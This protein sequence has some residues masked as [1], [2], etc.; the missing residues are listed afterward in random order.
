[1]V[2]GLGSALQRNHPAIALYVLDHHHGVG[3]A[4]NGCAGHDL[5]ALP[6]HHCNIQMPAGAKLANAFEARSG[7]LRIHGTHGKTIPHGPIEGRIVA[8]GKHRLSQNAAKGLLDFNLGM[9]QRAGK[10]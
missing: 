8:I 10:G 4:R 2:A 5:H 1:M 6:G 7:G 9:E 3:A